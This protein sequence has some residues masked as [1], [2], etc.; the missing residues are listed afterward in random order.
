[1]R[2]EYVGAHKS[3]YC[4][5]ITRSGRRKARE[6]AEKKS[7][8]TLQYVGGPYDGGVEEWVEPDGTILDVASDKGGPCHTYLVSGDKLIYKGLK[9]THR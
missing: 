9:D 5:R 2:Y 6:S 1:M 8:R 3:H 4:F 7:K